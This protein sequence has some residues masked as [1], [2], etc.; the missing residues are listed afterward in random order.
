MKNLPIIGV[1]GNAR[2]DHQGEYPGV[3]KAYVFN[4]FVAAIALAGGAPY[5]LP[6][7]TEDAILQS[8]VDTID[9]LMLT[10]GQDIHPSA[11]GEES[12]ESVKDV[13]L[14]RDA[15]DLK[16][17]E[18]AL[19][20]GKPILGICRGMQIMNVYF[21]GT[22]YQ[23]IAVGTESGHKNNKE[24]AMGKASHMMHLE[25]PSLMYSIFEEEEVHINS[26]H[27]QA[28]KEVASRFRVTGVSEDGL[29]EAIEDKDAS[30]PWLVGVQWHPEMMVY[31]YP[32]MLKLFEYF[33]QEARTHAKK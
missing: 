24:R 9:A 27:H 25:Y 12:L 20:A 17:F 11:Y 16:L 31:D 18:Y 15:F 6:V 29:I 3:E 28:I 4:D 1:S 7:F 26:F 5:I 23:D 21:G 14:K 8:Y 10:G 30:G 22:L 33:V 19:K 13:S 2:V 32:K